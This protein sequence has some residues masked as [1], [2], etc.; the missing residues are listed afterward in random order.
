M[1]L[2]LSSKYYNQQVFK[3]DCRFVCA[4]EVVAV[5]DELNNLWFRAKVLQSNETG[6]L[7]SPLL[8]TCMRYVLHKFIFI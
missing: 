7:V 3:E 1:F 6:V 8:S 2:L 4:G 5:Y